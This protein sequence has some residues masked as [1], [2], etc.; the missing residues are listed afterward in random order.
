MIL[1]FIYIAF[2]LLVFFIIKDKDDKIKHRVLL[3]TCF[4]LSWLAGSRDVNKWAD[5]DSYIICLAQTPTLTEFSFS[6]NPYG[7][8]ELGFYWLS[9]LIKT[10]TSFYPFYFFV[11]AAISIWFIYK[12]LYKYCCYPLFGL[13]IYIA[14]FFSARNMVQIRSGL[15]YA[16]LLIGIKFITERDWKKYFILVFIAYQFHHSALIAL[17][18]YFITFIKIKKW[19]VILGLVFA[20]II[21]GFFQGELQNYITDQLEDFDTNAAASYTTGVEV[22]KAKGLANPMIYFQTLI[23]LIYTFAEDK[24]KRLDNHYYTIRAAYLYSTMILIAFC[25]FLALSSRT[26]TMFATWEVIMIPSLIQ[27]YR[28]N[29]NLLYFVIS[30]GLVGIF[31]INYGHLF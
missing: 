27:V 10:I 31:V 5:T 21:G 6:S 28:K 22:E 14:R 8:S 12:G 16:V 26:S 15:A 2:L 11:I 17:P 18:L 19:H 13:A 25:M 1:V 9:V 24:L 4:V 20:F 7:Y 29:F 30:V 23:L 3:I